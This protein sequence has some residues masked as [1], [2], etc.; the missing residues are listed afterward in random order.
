M[1]LFFTACGSLTY[2]YNT[3]IDELNFKISENEVLT[4]QLRNTEEINTFGYC[5]D[6]SY[7]LIGSDVFVEHI[8]LES[9][10]KW[11]GL[12][13]GY[14]EYAFKEK[15]KLKSMKAMERIHIKNYSFSTFTINEQYRL[16]MI[17][18]FSVFRNT[19]II[20]YKGELYNKLLGRLKPDYKNSY[21]SLPLFKADYKESLVRNNIFKGYFSRESEDIIP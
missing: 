16:H 6:N 1:A 13:S 5:V 20:D 7:L 2:N 18:V 9:N 12:A 11:N 17:E 10:C 8:S 3:Q 15:L 19:F 14:F 4:Q 21:E